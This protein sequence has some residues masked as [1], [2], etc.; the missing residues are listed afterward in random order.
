MEKEKVLKKLEEVREE[1][2][3]VGIRDKKFWN[4]MKEVEE[5][6]TNPPK[7]KAG[8]LK[9]LILLY[10]LSYEILYEPFKK[11]G[12]ENVKKSCSQS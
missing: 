6:I 5:F 1:A 4:R 8:M 12:G 11:I 2:K 9:G 3:K 10:I 7:G